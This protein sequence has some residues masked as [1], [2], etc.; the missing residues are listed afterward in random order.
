M[1]VLSHML[2]L[3]LG[4]SQEHLLEHSWRVVSA[5]NLEGRDR[6]SNLQGKRK[7]E[8]RTKMHLE[9][10]AGLSPQEEPLLISPNGALAVHLV[11]HL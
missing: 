1:L 2:A 5:L 7:S 9:Q 11:S 10:G 4:T 6:Y 3:R 8:C